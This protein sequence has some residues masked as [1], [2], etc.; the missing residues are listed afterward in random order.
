MIELGQ[1]WTLS[2]YHLG[3]EVYWEVEPPKN[4]LIA[5]E[6][7]LLRQLCMQVDNKQIQTLLFLAAEQL[8]PCVCVGTKIKTKKK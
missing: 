3:C 2:R 6:S 7:L 1:H 4:S 8:Y 5:R